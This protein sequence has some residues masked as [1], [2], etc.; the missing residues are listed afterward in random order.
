MAGICV[1]IVTNGRAQDG[2][3]PAPRASGVRAPHKARGAFR[4][5]DSG[6]CGGGGRSAALAFSQ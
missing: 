1:C 6:P 3:G 4:S 5:V 2:R